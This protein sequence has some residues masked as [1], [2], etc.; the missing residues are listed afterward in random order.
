MEAEGAAATKVSQVTND[1]DSP[2][3]PAR[4]FLCQ[5]DLDLVQ[6]SPRTKC[7]EGP[8]A[9]LKRSEKRRDPRERRL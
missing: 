4:G 2:E 9:L 8:A 6:R 5:E 3:V 7:Y 1:K